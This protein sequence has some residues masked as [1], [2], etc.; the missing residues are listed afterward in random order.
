K[1]DRVNYAESLSEVEMDS[2]YEE[3]PKRKIHLIPQVTLKRFFD[4]NKIEDEQEI[5]D[6]TDFD[7]AY[8]NLGT[9]KMW[10]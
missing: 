5:D 6:L 1:R 10:K 3:R 8:H 2:D 9:S 7:H 4:K